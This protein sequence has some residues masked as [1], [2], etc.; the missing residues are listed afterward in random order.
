MSLLHLLL[1]ENGCVVLE[2]NIK[3][4]R[5]DKPTVKC[6]ASLGSVIFLK[7]FFQDVYMLNKAAAFN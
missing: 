3:S 2:C 7:M 5:R 4:D 6:N 1:I